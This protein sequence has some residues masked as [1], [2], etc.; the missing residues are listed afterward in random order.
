MREQILD[1]IRKFTSANGGRVPRARI[2]E[3]ETGIRESAWRGVFWA[4]WGDAVKE[5]GFKPNVKQG[6]IEEEV[7]LAKIAEACR[8]FGKFP[9]AMELRMFQKREDN[10]RTLKASQDSSDRLSISP[11]GSLSGQK[12]MTTAPTLLRC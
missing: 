8:H 2:F 5:A 6:R 3:R 11:T 7:F 12:P 4:R 1:E 10:F 9:T